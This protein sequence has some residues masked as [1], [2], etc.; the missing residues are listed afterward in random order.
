MGAS[1]LNLV[2]TKV[3]VKGEE[4]KF[5]SLHLRQG[6]NRHHTFTVMV[7]YL[8]PNN[9]FQQTPEKFIG[10]IGET[11]SI[12]FVHR[13]TGESYDFE[14]IITQVEMV[15]SMGETGGVAIHGTSPTILYENNRTLDS[16]MD[17]SLSTIIKEV[18]Q[19]YGKVNLVSNPKYATPIPYMAQYNESVFDFMNRLSALYGEWFYYDGTKVYFGKP[20]R[21]NTEKIVYDMDL[22]EVRLVANLVPGKSARYDYVAQENKQHNADTPAKPD[23]MND[24]QSIAHSCSEKAYTAKTTSAADP[25]VTDKAELDEQMRIVKN[26]SGANLLNIKGIGKTCRIRIGEIIDVSFPDRMKLPPLGKFRI[27][28]I[29]HEVR[30]DGHYSNSFVGVPDGTVH[31]PVPDAKRPLALPELATVKENND[32]KGQGRVKVAFDWQKNGKT[33]NWVRV[34]TPNAGVS[35]AVPKNRGWV[36]VPEVGDQVMVSYEHGNPDRPYVTGSV[37]HSGSGKGGD[38]DNKVKSIITRSG[39]AIV[40]DDETGSIVITDQTGKQL[41]M[42]DGT[43][44][45]TVM[46][47]KSITLTNEAESVI[48]MDDKSI[49]LQAD[50]IALEGRKS[51]TLLSGNE[52]MVL[53]SEKSII[54]SSGTNIKQEAEKDYDVAAKN[55]TVNGVNL[56]IEGKGNVTVSGGIVKFN[57]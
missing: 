16:W 53:S 35:G 18:T 12:S 47:K 24:L 44:A 55:G 3:T 50:T 45:I 2:A 42:L 17:Q 21:D 51:V 22:E 37:F 8:S 31:I 38:K 54:S 52:C 14:G 40:F 41:I 49:G 43:D 4:Q 36:F 33:T 7:N 30:R 32:D 11:A 5:V 34:Q 13:Q 48:V 27:V 25:H 57:S 26:A 20:D 46:A 19:E 9:T 1:F 15:G 23:G 28:G 56:M 39:N 29:E 6:F 10:Y